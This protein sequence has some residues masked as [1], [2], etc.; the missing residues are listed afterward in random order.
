MIVSLLGLTYE[1]EKRKVNDVTFMDTPGLDD[2]KLRKQ[3]AKAISTAL[4]QN[5]YYQIV[6]VVTLESGRVRSNDIALVKLV[7]QSATEIS[8]YGIIFNKLTKPEIKEIKK[9]PDS[10][11][12]LISQLDINLEETESSRPIPVPLLLERKDELEGKENAAI[13]IHDLQRF[14]EAVLF[15]KIHKENVFQIDIENYVYYMQKFE[16]ILSQLMKLNNLIE[17]R[18]N[19]QKYYVQRM[20]EMFN[21]RTKRYEEKEAQYTHMLKSL[22]EN[23]KRSDQD[24]KKNSEDLQ[25]MHSK[26]K[27]LKQQLEQHKESIEN[28]KSRSLSKRMTRFFRQSQKKKP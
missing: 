11:Q 23:Q 10:V 14:M 19:D 24:N 21:E 15:N 1:F 8:Y 9:Q 28:Y 27:R 13:C 16:E 18:E 6:F 26:I 2:I 25:N 17:K 5:G 3:A 7:L 12:N 4:K 22:W 20:Q